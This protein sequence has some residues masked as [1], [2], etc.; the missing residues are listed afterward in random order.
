M[1]MRCF[2]AGVHVRTDSRAISL[3]PV[4]GSGLYPQ[5]L[6]YPEFPPVLDTWK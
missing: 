4:D 3:G 5:A 6:V 2:W 1:D